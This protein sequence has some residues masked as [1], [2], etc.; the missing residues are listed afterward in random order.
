MVSRIDRERVV[1]TALRL[2]NEGGLDGLTLRRI[3]KELDVQAPAL[4]WHFK[5]KQELLDE[6]ATEIFR[7]LFRSRLAGG[8]PGPDCRWPSWQE[9]LVRTC[10]TLR[11]ELLSYRDGGK[12]VAGTRMTDDTFAGPLEL[13]L[14]SFT[15][16]GFP[17]A[18]AVTA[19]WTAYNYTIGLVIEEQSVHPDPAHPEVRDPA[20]DL[21][22]RESRLGAAYPLAARAGRQMFGDVEESFHAGLRLI[23]AGIE[24]TYVR[25]KGS[26]G[27]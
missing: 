13:F 11:Q 12:V 10:T 7:R 26:A 27:R 1:E 24:A 22:D 21:A 15:A 9:M 5:N 19:W 17:P 8:G 23:V 14:S 3:A 2:L 16:A 25:G 20:Y 4:Y 6:M 18:D